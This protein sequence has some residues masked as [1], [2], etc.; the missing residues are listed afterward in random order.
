[1]KETIFAFGPNVRSVNWGGC[2][3]EEQETLLGDIRVLDLTDEK[4]VYCAKLLADHGADVIRIEPP[5]GHPMRN[6]GPFVNDETDPEKSLYWF[7]FNTSKR[8]IT[9]NLENADGRE[10]FRSLIKTADVLLETYAPGYLGG[11]GLGYDE[12]RKV[13]PRLVQTSITPFGQTGPFKDF[14][15]SDMV[16]QAMGGLMFLA[17]YPEDPPNRLGCSQ[18]YQCA[19]VQASVGTMIALYAREIT[20]EGQTVDVSLQQSVLMAMETAMQHYDMRK[21]IISRTGTD[22]AALPGMGIY[23]CQDGYVLAFVVP[24]AGAGWDA[25]L[26]WMDSEGGAGDLGGPEYQETIGV[27][28]DLKKLAALAGDPERL[29]ALT[30]QVAEIQ[31]LLKAF[32]MGKTKHEISDE[33]AD[34]RIMMVPIETM[35]DLVN[36]PQLKALGFFNGVE[37]PE[38]GMTIQYP[39]APCYQISDAQWR[40]SRRA[41]LIGE[42]NDEIYAKELGLPREQIDLLK[43]S[44]AI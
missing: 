25:I 4:G 10:L 12:L 7:Q 19:G 43:Q 42:H 44:G 20:G 38:L 5:G 17:G 3:M 6:L 22:E 41:P 15:G 11:L 23:A 39:G 40:I 31:A 2:R 35:E 8:G 9:L 16:A 36:S 14:E 13:N 33:A 26:D 37:H 21:E 34:R 24:H 18:A 28:M 32:L 29:A 27:L 1:M 30:A